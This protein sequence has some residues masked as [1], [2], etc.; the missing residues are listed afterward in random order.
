VE[1]LTSRPNPSGG[2]GGD[3]FDDFGVGMIGEPIE[4]LIALLARNFSGEGVWVGFIHKSLRISE[5][6][7]I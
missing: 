5:L 4:E 7:I 2:G 3:K 1:V 6:L